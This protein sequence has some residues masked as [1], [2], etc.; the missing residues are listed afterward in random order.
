MNTT[1]R[2]I[3][4][5]SS[6]RVVRKYAS[7]YAYRAKPPSSGGSTNSPNTYT[8][9]SMASQIHRFRLG[10]RDLKHSLKHISSQP[11]QIRRKIIDRGDEVAESTPEP[12]FGTAFGQTLLDSSPENDVELVRWT[13]QP[14]QTWP[15]M[16]DSL[17]GQSLYGPSSNS[18]DPF[19]ALS[20]NISPREQVLLQYYCKRNYKSRR[21]HLQF[22]LV[23]VSL[24]LSY[25]LLFLSAATR[26]LK[27]LDSIHSSSQCL[28]VWQIFL[29]PVSCYLLMP[30]LRVDDSPH[31]RSTNFTA[32]TNRRQVDSPLIP[33]CQAFFG[34]A[35]QDT[36]AF[37]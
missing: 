20:L 28:M 32:V 25:S 16:L 5:P 19:N 18:I 37:Q 15:E 2:A 27:F 24:G 3:I 21:C 36:A 22:Y 6:K 33:Y 30:V 35:V 23:I 9:G 29:G 10:R 11:P 14:R 7:R 4:D 13:R 17:R 8:H 26:A 31:I 12:I 1:S 34:L